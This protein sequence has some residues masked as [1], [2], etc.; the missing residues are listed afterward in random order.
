MLTSSLPQGGVCTE[1]Q[2]GITA[3]IL[4]GFVILAALLLLLVHAWLNFPVLQTSATGFIGSSLASMT[5]TALLMLKSFGATAT[6]APQPLRGFL[7][8]LEVFAFRLDMLDIACLLGPNTL[9]SRYVLELSLMPLAWALLALVAGCAALSPRL[10]RKCFLNVPCLLNTCGTLFSTFFISMSMLSVEPFRC[11]EQPTR[12]LAL[13]RDLTVECWQPG[14]HRGLV[15][16]GVF[17][18]LLYPVLFISISFLMM[19]KK[20]RLY[21]RWG[22][23]LLSASRFLFGRF[24]PECRPWFFSSHRFGDTMSPWWAETVFS[25]RATFIYLGGHCEPLAPN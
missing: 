25:L 14:P 3:G 22:K 24:R 20:V 4:I 7:S 10:R 1:C 2:P 6:L 13:V 5:I 23:T 18:I 11:E 16:I 15:A 19:W 12:Q 17:A 8:V 21:R 9:S